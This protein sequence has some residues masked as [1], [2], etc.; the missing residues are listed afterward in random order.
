[1]QAAD[2]FQ[3]KV[4]RTLI[5]L[6]LP[7]AILFAPYFAVLLHHYP[8][9]ADYWIKSPGSTLVV[10]FVASLAV[11]LIIDNLGTFIEA[12]IWD[13][14]LTR[15]DPEHM[16][17]W[18]KYL[19]CRADEVLVAHGYLRSLLLRMKFELDFSVAL[20]FALP[21]LYWIGKLKDFWCSVFDWS[22]LKYSVIGIVIILYLLW[23]SY[24]SAKNLSKV[25]SI[26]I[27]SKRKKK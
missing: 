27:S 13:K 14:L 24:Q 26:I 5:T 22:F 4:L 11:G 20:F 23:E 12:R 17:N 25:R 6:V 9:W 7:G 10:G 19:A 3:R 16:N 21:G 15:V 1:M 8:N 18:W 2:I